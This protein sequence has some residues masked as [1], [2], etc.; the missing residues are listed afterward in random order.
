MVAEYR[1]LRAVFDDEL[2]SL[3]REYV[4]SP[5]SWKALAA[6]LER[7][8][9]PW[10]DDTTTTDRVELREEIVTRAIDAAG[11]DLRRDLGDP[12]GWTWGALHT[13]T[14]REA[15]L[16]ESGIGP[17]EWY[18][19]RGPGPAG[20]AGGAI[21]NT[22]WRY[23]LAYDDPY[24]EDDVPTDDLRTLFGVTNLPSYRLAIDMTDLD[25]ARIVITTGQSGNPFD[26]HYGDLIDEWTTGGW[27]PLPFTPAAVD[28]ATVSTL[29]LAPPG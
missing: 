23:E 14:W 3:A 21:D 19:N 17:L 11:A 1:L 22:Y 18:F 5:F 27:I 6:I 24:D 12:A 8:E 10:W 2:G 29:T 16:G 25:D 13:A 20:G 4:G 15:T 26:A 7:Q 9:D 28:E